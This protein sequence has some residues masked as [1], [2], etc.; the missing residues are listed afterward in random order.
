MINRKTPFLECVSSDPGEVVVHASDVLGSPRR[1]RWIEY[2]PHVY[3]KCAR[4]LP[5]ARAED[6]VLFVG[7]PDQSYLNWLKSIAMGPDIVFGF[8]ENNNNRS[9][10]ELILDN[11]EPVKKLVAKTGKKPVYVPFYSGVKEQ[12]CAKLLGGSFFG[13]DVTACE[14]YFN[15]HT[16]KDTCRELGIPTVGGVAHE[17]VTGGAP[18]FSE[19]ENLVLALLSN[20]RELIIR[21]ADGATGFSVYKTNQA[22]IQD[23]LAKI[24]VNDEHTVLVEPFLKVIASPNDQWAISRDGKLHHIG[25]SAQ[26]FSG[27]EHAGNLKG[28]YFS[29]RTYDYIT[30][31]S[32]AIGERM[33]KDGYVGLFGVDY[34][35]SDEGIFPIEN[36]A[37]LNGST[38]VFGL[39]DCV[40]RAVG[41]VP[42]WKFFKARTKASSFN[43]LKEQLTSLLYDGSKINVVFP[44]DVEILPTTGAFTLILL[45]EDIYHIEYLEQALSYLGIERL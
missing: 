23:V 18:N 11:P 8:G 31:V 43:E 13:S 37:R 4:A 34:I 27:L 32:F 36:N 17:I 21:G 9:L 5:I 29:N 35:I 42:C 39:V 14:R 38:Y 15:K 22:N 40:K 28:Q 16:F 33:V 7:T 2:N 20:Y 24:R 1:E 6:I 45:A 44:F 19:L 25:I 10:A 12:E 3:A 30:K 26:L 41:E